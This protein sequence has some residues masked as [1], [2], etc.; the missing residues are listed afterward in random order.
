MP[1]S[2]E[3]ETKEDQECAG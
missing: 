1:D 3:E 2:K